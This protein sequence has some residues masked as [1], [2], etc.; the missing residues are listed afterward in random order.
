MALLL[1]VTTTPFFKMI[2]AFR[3]LHMPKLLAN[4]IMF[5]Y[6]FIFVLLDEMERM[7]LARIARGYKG[8]KSLLDR[9]AFATISSTIGMTF[10][11]SNQRATNIYDALLS[12]GYDGEVRTLGK[13]KAGPRDALLATTFGVVVLMT[14]MLELG[15]LQWRI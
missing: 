9:R 5:T 8:G 4:M 2:K 15:V 3:A 12:R 1:L 14:T 13:L 11:R 6:R 7:K 10:V